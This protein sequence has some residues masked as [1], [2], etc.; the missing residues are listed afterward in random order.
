MDMGE[1]G[2]ELLLRSRAAELRAEAEDWRRL[3]ESGIEPDRRPLALGD[4]LARIGDRLLGA[5]RSLTSRG[6]SPRVAVRDEKLPHRQ[7]A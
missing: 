6:T 4:T 1:Y 3:R 5:A 2:L 7:R